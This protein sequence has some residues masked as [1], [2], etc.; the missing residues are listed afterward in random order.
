MNRDDKKQWNVK[1][2]VEKDPVTFKVDT[3]AEVT[4]LSD[5]TYNSIQKSVPQ[6]KKSNQ[7]LWGPNR[8]HLD[9]AGET[10]L[11]LTYKGK[12][13]PQRVF[14]IQNLQNNLLGL[15]KHLKSSTRHYSQG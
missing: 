9:V 15:S 11:K 1:V 13:S 6:L 4:A 8:S 2:L 3:G 7:T 5:A 12:S 10:T 14:V